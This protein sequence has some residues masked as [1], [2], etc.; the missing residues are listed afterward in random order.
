MDIGVF[1]LKPCVYI[2]TI[3]QDINMF[4]CMILIDFKCT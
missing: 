1:R 2:Y 4:L 3:Y